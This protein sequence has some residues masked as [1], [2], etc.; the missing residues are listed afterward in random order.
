LHKMDVIH[1]R[2][3]FKGVYRERQVSLA[4]EIFRLMGILREDREGRENW[5]T[6]GVRFFDAPCVIIIGAE[7]E[8]VRKR[9]LRKHYHL[10]RV[11][12]NYPSIASL[13]FSSR[14]SILNGF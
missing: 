2:P 1:L 11:G 4:K 14:V 6:R 9:T 5:M 10:G 12:L 8:L 3:P 13:I 7:K